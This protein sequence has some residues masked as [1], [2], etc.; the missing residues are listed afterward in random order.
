MQRRRALAVLAGAAAWRPLRSA[1]QTGRP[2]VLAWSA[3][4]LWAGHDGDER[5]A[6]LGASPLAAVDPAAHAAGVVAA[7]AAGRMRAWRHDGKAWREAWS[8]GFDAAVHAL[9]ASD[10]GAWVLA[11]HG[12]ALSVADGAGQVRRTYVGRDALGRNQGAASV[13]RYHARRHS[14]VVAWPALGELWEIQLDPAAPPVFEGLVHDYRMGEGIATPGHLG[15]RRAPLGAPV[16]PVDFCDARVPWVAG[17]V[18]DQVH[19]VHLD[20]R[21]RIA[22]LPLAQARPRSAVLVRDLDSLQWWLPAADAVHV[23]DIS[24]WQPV[25]RHAMPGPVR[26][27]IAL[28]GAVWAWLDHA[29]AVHAWQAGRWRPVEEAPAGIARIA[30]TAAG[31]GLLCECFEPRALLQLDARG[32]VVQRWRWPDS[33]APLQG[34][35]GFTA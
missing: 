31:D 11:A 22:S 20:V 9:C 33:G 8:L 7:D 29:R 18:D 17:A 14:F 12:H 27:L 32:R 21:R 15:V 19:V 23:F 35:A 1:A 28:P 26:A 5:L 2:R 16:P 24:R 13:L 30:P 4:G 25:A 3:A 6:T 10:D 34:I